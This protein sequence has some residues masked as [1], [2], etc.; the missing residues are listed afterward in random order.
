MTGVNSIRLTASPPPSRTQ[1]RCIATP[2]LGAFDLACWLLAAAILACATQIRA[3]PDGDIGPHHSVRKDLPA[4][5]PSGGL[6]PYK[7]FGYNEAGAPIAPRTVRGQVF[8]LVDNVHASA[9]A[10]ELERLQRDLVGDGSTVIRRDVAGSDSVQSVKVLN[11]A[12]YNADPANVKAVFLFGR[13]PVPAVGR[14]APDGHPDH[15]GARP[16]DIFNHDSVES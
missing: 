1:V 2:R 8:L 12:D 10:S 6:V 15:V 3:K 9:L 4:K 14:V 7:G 11:T 5:R 16:A 13:V